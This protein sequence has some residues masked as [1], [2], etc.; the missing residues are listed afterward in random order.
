M[1]PNIR[2]IS[3]VLEVVKVDVPA[4]LGLDI[5]DESALH[6]DYINNRLVNRVVMSKH[7]TQLKYYDAW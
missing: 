5:I 1:P 2:P 7:G 4:L 6:A 3:V